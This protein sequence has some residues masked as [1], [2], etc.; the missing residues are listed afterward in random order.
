M[1]EEMAFGLFGAL[2]ALYVLAG[3]LVYLG[4]AV[5]YLTKK[6]HIKG[7]SLRPSEQFRQLREYA[8]ESQK[9][10]VRSLSVEIAKNF[11]AI[12]IGLLS[13]ALVL[14]LVLLST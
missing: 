7:P 11:S 9:D 5:P 2:I 10:G 14:V 12:S 3:N 6:G 4:R 1:N 13:V 8:V